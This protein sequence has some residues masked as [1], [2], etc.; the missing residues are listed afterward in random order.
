MYIMYIIYIYNICIHVIHIYIHTY[1]FL[2]LPGVSSLFLLRFFSFDVDLFVFLKSLLNL[3]QY[4]FCF[5]LCLFGRKACGL[6]APQPGVEPAP[7]HWKAKCKPL[8][9]QGSPPSLSLIG[10]SAALIPF[11]WQFNL[12]GFHC[13]NY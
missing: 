12:T 6:L 1:I 4:C 5:M 8:D 2:D 9:H 13:E 7:P 10:R 11:P 3:L